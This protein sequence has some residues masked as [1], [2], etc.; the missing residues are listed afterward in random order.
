MPVY[1]G[2]E[3]NC[4]GGEREKIWGLTAWVLESVLDN[5][6]VPQLDEK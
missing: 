3:V 4:S 5:V 6:I 2:D 1:G